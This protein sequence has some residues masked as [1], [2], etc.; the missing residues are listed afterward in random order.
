MHTA[1]VTTAEAPTGDGVCYAFHNGRPLKDLIIVETI[2]DC[3]K[4]TFGYKFM[5]FGCPGYTGPCERATGFECWRGNEVNGRHTLDIKECEGTPLTDL[6]NNKT[7]VGASLH[8]C[9][10]FPQGTYT[11]AYNGFQVPLGGWSRQPVF[12]RAQFVAK[13]VP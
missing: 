4:H 1:V 11:L 7:N 12:D 8:R 13:G 10:G 3:L 9:N 5:G 2:A 6:G